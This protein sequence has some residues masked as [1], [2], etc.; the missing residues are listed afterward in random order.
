MSLVELLTES[1]GKQSVSGSV[2]GVVIGIVSSIDD[3][4]GLGRVRVKYPWLHDKSES[5]WARVVSFMAGQDRG[6]VFRPELEDEV[7]IMF[8][9]GDMRVPYIIGSLWNGKDTIPGKKGED[10]DNNVRFIKSRSGH[11]IILDD[12][13]GSEKI[14]VIDKGGNN[15]IVIQEKSIEISSSKDITISAPSGKITLDADQ[16]EIKS[17]STATFTAGGSMD[18]KTDL[19]MNIEGATVN[20]N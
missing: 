11:L 14:E 9:H 10:A 18:V 8:E 5:P 15:K 13:E 4:D 19:T 16:L 12:T 2:Y 6:A 1:Q 17:T 7:L 20:I 3:P